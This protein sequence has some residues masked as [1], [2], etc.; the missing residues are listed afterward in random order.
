MVHRRLHVNGFAENAVLERSQYSRWDFWV[1]YMSRTDWIALVIMGLAFFHIWWALA[2]I[3]PYYQMFEVP[4]TPE[5][6]AEM[7]LQTSI[8]DSAVI[9]VCLVCLLVK[10]KR[11]KQ[12][13]M[14][15]LITAVA[16]IVLFGMFP[17]GIRNF[18]FWEFDIIVATIA[19][20]WAITIYNTLT[21]KS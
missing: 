10:S 16:Y 3:I 13:L 7:I 14:S 4:P 15:T 20:I 19:I 1:M 18:R 6:I 8:M 12:V 2:V 11:L 21:K 17:G 5:E 9:A